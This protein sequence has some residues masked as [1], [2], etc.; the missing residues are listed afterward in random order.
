MEA[1]ALGHYVIN[2]GGGEGRGSKNLR[3]V[4]SSICRTTPKSTENGEGEGEGDGDLMNRYVIQARLRI[5][6]LGCFHRPWL[7]DCL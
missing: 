1:A 5:Q 7:V 2:F 4:L 3:T 6:N